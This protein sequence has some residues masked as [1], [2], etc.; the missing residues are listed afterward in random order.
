[1]RAHDREA[2][3]APAGA[4]TVN[5]DVNIDLTV[6]SAAASHRAPFVRHATATGIPGGGDPRAVNAAGEGGHRPAHPAAVIVWR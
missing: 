5:I 6:F 3:Q 2:P 1:M 4:C